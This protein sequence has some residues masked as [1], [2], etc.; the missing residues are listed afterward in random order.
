MVY[1]DVDPIAVAHSELILH[2]IPNATVINADL[3]RPRE[4]LAHPGLTALI[5]FAEPVAF[6]MVAVLHFVPESDHPEEAIATL[7]SIAAPGS[8]LVISHGYDARLDAARP[9]RAGS[10]TVWPGR[11]RKCS[12]SIARPT[13]SPSAPAPACSSCSTAGRW[14]NPVWSGYRSGTR[15]GRTRW[16]STVVELRGGRDGAERLRSLGFLR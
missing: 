15:T 2:G 8:H 4:I 16:A 1:V 10:A 14:S 11:A 13:R 3:R 9:Q 7:H 5:D 6:L 12:V